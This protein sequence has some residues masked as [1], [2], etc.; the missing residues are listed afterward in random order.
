M[1][2][3]ELAV[4]FIAVAFLAMVYGFAAQRFD[5][6]PKDLLDTAFHQA[7]SY[8]REKKE[9]KQHYLHP[10]VYTR[11]GAN[12]VNKSAVQPGL[13]LV[14]SYWSDMGWKS[15]VK[16][17]DEQGRTLHKWKTDIVELWPHGPD[18]LEFLQGYVHGSHLLSNGD[19]LFNI[20]H[21]SL[22]MI[23]ACGKLK[24]HLDHNTHHSIAL[25][26]D[27][28]FWIPGNI[29]LDQKTPREKPDD[30]H[31]PGLPLSNKRPVWDD[32]L[33]KVTPQG[34]VLADISVLEILY[35]N[36][37]QRYIPKI[38]KRRH[39]DVLHLNDIDILDASLADQYPLF[40][41]GDLALSLRHLHMI[42]VVDPDTGVVKWHATDPWIEQHDP[43]F[44]GNGWITV[45]DNNP[46]FRIANQS[47]RG[48][49]L[50]G[51]QIIDIQ[52]HTGEV[53]IAYPRKPDDIFFTRTGG[54]QQ[55]QANGNLLITETNAGRIFEIDPDGE[56]VW[57]WFNET[58]EN[59][60]V[61]EV[62]EG[63]RYPITPQQVSEWPCHVPL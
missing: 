13:T 54:K 45:F 42:L 38:S 34:E 15:G 46:G 53:K 14:A 43:D 6:F 58:T 28:N 20:E 57:E 7:S 52:P 5:L 60:K 51:S 62:T 31:Y 32:R 26:A 29:K 41:A 18:F 55:K 12:T 56:L 9:L 10:A 37:L 17:I 47:D 8:S 4:R 50:G 11:Q 2:R 1:G 61:A 27:G 24:W 22:F 59:G 36:D 3:I 19:L 21:T 63:T 23:D 48:Q 25:D 35:D 44:T 16:L 39:G 30:H 49:M 40:E 33:L